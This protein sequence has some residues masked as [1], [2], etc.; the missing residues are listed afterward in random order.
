MTST[1]VEKLSSHKQ[2]L[3]AHF[4]KASK[5]LV[6]CQILE[7]YVEKGTLHGCICP[8][9]IGESADEGAFPIVEDFHDTLE[10][11]WVWSYYTKVSSKQTFKLNIKWAWK[12]I[13]EN[14]KRFIKEETTNGSLYDCSFLLFTG[15]FYEKVFSDNKYEKLILNAG[16]HLEKY[17][18]KLESTKGR[19]YYDPFW[20]TFCLGLAAKR[21]R[22]EKWFR[23]AETFV[24]N[25]IV[26]AKS[27]LKCRK[28][29]TP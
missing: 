3:E 23:T 20:M 21:L 8:W 1:I 24:K 11:I 27:L 28:G 6:K 15:T 9:E 19:E 10:A 16:N 7:P 18:R 4:K 13:I 2:N 17:L 5:F 12:C 25:N 14:W 22:H 26:F 29:T